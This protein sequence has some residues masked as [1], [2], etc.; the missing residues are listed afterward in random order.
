MAAISPVLRS[1]GRFGRLPAA[2]VPKMTHP[3][4]GLKFAGSPGDLQEMRT[5]S[6][7]FPYVLRGAVALVA[8]LVAVVASGCGQSTQ[9]VAPPADVDGCA[10]SHLKPTQANLAQVQAATLCLLNAQ[11]TR[12]GLAPLSEDP[13][14]EAAAV[15]HSADMAHRDYF[16][17]NS[18]EGI[19][20]WMRIGSAGYRAGLVGENLAWGEH[21]KVTPAHAMRMWMESDGHRDNVLEPRYTQ[22]GIGLAYDA[23][24][25]QPV[26]RGAVIYTT[27]FG[28]AAVAAG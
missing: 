2:S 9:A 3:A 28:S 24:E 4:P 7:G 21:P 12:H 11:R 23:P 10:G 18:P 16:D 14:L 6:D 8:V 17:H 15:A 19:E 1:E 25:E 22:I 20:P 13:T 26:P 5:R 27:T